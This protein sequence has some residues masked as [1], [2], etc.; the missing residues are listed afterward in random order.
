[1]A[2]TESHAPHKITTSLPHLASFID[3]SLLHPTLTDAQ[4]LSGLHTA[5]HHRVAAVCVKPYSVPLARQLLAG[6]P[7]RVCTVV[8]FPHGNST[9]AIK[10]A[11]AREAVENGASEVDL[12]VNV[13]K[14]K[15]QD[16]GYVEQEITP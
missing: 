4:I 10:V 3:H 13:G 9:T 6:S 11:E 2:N 16:W 7:V 8:G 14:V 1:M 12:V 15:S 5:L